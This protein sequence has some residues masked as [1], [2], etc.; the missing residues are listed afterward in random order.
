M[1]ATPALRV[2]NGIRLYGY[3]YPEYPELIFWT[4]QE[5]KKGQSC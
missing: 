2:H 3:V 4:M 5:P 1:W